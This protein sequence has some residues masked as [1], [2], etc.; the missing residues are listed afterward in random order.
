MKASCLE[1]LESIPP[2]QD[3]TVAEVIAR[4]ERRGVVDLGRRAEERD[5]NFEGLRLRVVRALSWLWI[6][7]FVQL[8]GRNG[9]DV[10]HRV[11]RRIAERTWRGR[12]YLTGPVPPRKGSAQ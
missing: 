10:Y 4:L 6:R 12:I 5:A 2:G 9:T 3:V 1:I 11:E 7:G 8:G